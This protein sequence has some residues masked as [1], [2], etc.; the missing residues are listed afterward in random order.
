[1]EI[2]GLCPTEHKYIR[3]FVE[4]M[5]TL[6]STPGDIVGIDIAGDVVNESLTQLKEQRKQMV[7]LEAN[8]V[9]LT[10]QLVENISVSKTAIN[11]SINYIE[12]QLKKYPSLKKTKP[13][14]EI[15]RNQLQ[16]TNPNMFLASVTF[17]KLQNELYRKPTLETMIEKLKDSIPESMVRKNYNLTKVSAYIDI[18]REILID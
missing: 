5:S 14:L 10:E 6:R 7:S 11:T 13:D 9:L 12:E 16:R 1:M 8:L 15:K 3:T 4:S 17:L 18:N 2:D